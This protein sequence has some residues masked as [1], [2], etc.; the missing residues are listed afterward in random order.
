MSD[1]LTHRDIV[2]RITRLETL[3]EGDAAALLRIET[4]LSELKAGSEAARGQIITRL[5]KLE[6][7][8]AVQQ[9]VRAEA[10]KWRNRLYVVLRYI[11]PP[12]LAATVA[13]WF[14][15]RMQ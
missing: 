14:W 13:I 4:M 1:E 10:D 12:S 5:E 7:A 9:G 15:E 6:L 3:R 11:L 2:E 8:A